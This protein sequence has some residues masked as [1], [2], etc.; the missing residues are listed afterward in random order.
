MGRCVCRRWIC[1]EASVGEAVMMM[2]S[3]GRNVKEMRDK[4]RKVSRIALNL[5]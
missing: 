4:T 1:L 2:D 3:R 5:N